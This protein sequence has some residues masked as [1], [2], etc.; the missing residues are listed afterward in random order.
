MALRLT[1]GA[2]YAIRAMIHIA[3]LPEETVALRRDI[4]RVQQIP[5]EFIAKILQALVRAGLLRSTR[6]SGG[7]FSLAR[8]TEAINLLEVV[9]AI[10][11]PLSLIACAPDPDNCDHSAYC[12]ADVVWQDVQSRIASVLREATLE[13]LISSRRNHAGSTGPSGG[14]SLPRMPRA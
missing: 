2:D 13:R 9:E 7:G 3:S 4:A 11:G 1:Q 8:S 14:R 6:G 5:S 10:D 12:P